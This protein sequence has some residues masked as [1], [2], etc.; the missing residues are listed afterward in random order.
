MHASETIG[1]F[2]TRKPKVL[3]LFVAYVQT[4]GFIDER[5]PF[6]LKLKLKLKAFVFFFGLCASE[7]AAKAQCLFQ[8]VRPLTEE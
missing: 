2:T 8:Q 1:F 3:H 5:E 6:W 4:Q 7:R